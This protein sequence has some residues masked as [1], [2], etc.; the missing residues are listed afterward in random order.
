MS[1]QLQIKKEYLK[2]VPRPTKERYEEIKQDI[3]TQGQ[4]LPIIINEK[5]IILDGYTRFQICNDLRIEQKI[6]AKSFE[7]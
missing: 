1:L 7:N 4:Q 6:I 2:A 3:Q 5:C